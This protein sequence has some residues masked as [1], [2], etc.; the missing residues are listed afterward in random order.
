MNKYIITTES[1]SDLTPEMIERY[2]IKVIPMH[3]TMGE[4]T[5]PDG[6]FDVQKL[7]DFYDETGIL[8]KTS[9]T[10]PQDNI[11]A[12]KEIFAK[13]PDAHIIHIGYSAVT[14]VSFNSAH[15]AA[16]EFENI[17]LVD[18]KHIALG[19]ATIVRATAEYTEENPEVS[20]EEIIDLWRI[21]EKELIRFVYLKHLFT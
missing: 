5:Y 15:I 7:F 19:A 4:E 11:E 9:G 13:Y 10:T 8:P 12:Y 2:N 1:G 18:C 6:S 16:K 3:V 20:P 17:H 21:F 14:T